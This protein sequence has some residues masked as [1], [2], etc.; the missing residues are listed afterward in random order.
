DVFVHL[1]AGKDLADFGERKMAEP[2]AVYK[3]QVIREINGVAVSGRR[4]AKLL[5]QVRQLTRH[6]DN[7]VRQTAFLAHS[8]LLPQT[9]A[10]ERHDDFVATIDDSA[11]PAMIREAA[12][13][14]LSYHNHPS[15]LLKL[16][17]VAADPKHP[18]WNAAVSRIG[19][20]GRGFSVSLLRQLQK[21]KLTDKQSTLLADSLKRLTDRE[22]QVQTVESWDMARRISLAVFAKQTSDP[23]AKVIRE[24]VMNSKTQMPDA[25]RAELKKSWDFKAVNDFWLPTPVAEFS[26][27]YDELRADVVK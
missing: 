17:Q 13:L 11:E 9:P 18:A 7:E 26:K 6:S 4:D 16:H 22:S 25:E 8:Y 12:L 19:D 23:N 2:S 14:G 27:G 24:W 20:I 5:E 3:H 15:V 21:A 10:T 1:A